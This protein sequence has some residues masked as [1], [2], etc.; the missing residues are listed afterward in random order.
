MKAYLK[1]K[2][3]PILGS[4]LLFIFL[5]LYFGVICAAKVYFWDLIYLDT[6]LFIAGACYLAYGYCRWR[7]I[8]DMLLKELP[9]DSE[10]IRKLLGK[11]MSDILCKIEKEHEEEICTLLEERDEL[12]EYMTKWTHEVKLPLSALGLMNER[13]IDISLKKEMQDCLERIQ[14]QLNTMMMSNKQKS[15]ENDVKFERVSLELCVNEAL[16]N[17]SYFLIQEHFQ[18]EKDCGDIA[19]YSDRRWLV[20]ILDQLIG[21]SVKYRQEMPYLSFTARQVSESEAVLLVQDHGIGIEPGELPFIFDRGYIG[22]NL[23]SGTYRST[24][25]GLYFVKT[26]AKHLGI[27]LQVYSDIGKGMRFELYFQDNAEYLMV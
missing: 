22:S 15:M 6:V 8:P 5:N 3:V 12:A 2:W 16:K 21:N 7:R 9:K 11:Q 4:S 20:Y 14:Q 26:A 10:D 23:R 18:I 17:Q 13:N 27:R 25:M 19:V 1:E 24:G